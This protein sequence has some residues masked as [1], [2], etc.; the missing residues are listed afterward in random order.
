MHM[1]ESYIVW[2][3]GHLQFFQICQ[4]AQNSPWYGSRKRII[5]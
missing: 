5:A 3:D 2:A 1:N 4:G